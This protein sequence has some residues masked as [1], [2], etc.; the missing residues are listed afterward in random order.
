[1]N[2]R[3]PL[4]E[5]VA[6]V[7]PPHIAARSAPALIGRAARPICVGLPVYNGE[8][9]LSASL[10]DLLAQRDVD[11]E[12]VIADNCSS[13]ATEEICREAARRDGRVRYIRRERNIGVVANH[14][15][16]VHETDSELFAYGAADDEYRPNRLCRLAEALR[17]CPDAVLAFSAVLEIDAEGDAVGTWGNQCR[18]D[19]PDAAVRLYDLFALRHPFV[20]FYGLIRRAALLR[21]R[22]HPPMK[23]GDRM[24]VAELALQGTFASVPAEL[25]LRRQH[26]EKTSDLLHPRAFYPSGR[27]VTLPNIDEGRW[28]VGGIGRAPLTALAR[29]RCYAALRPWLRQNIVP[30]AKNLVRAGID[31]ANPA[32]GR[33]P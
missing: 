24:L 18:T 27:R 16:L 33:R 19:H 26:P 1:M 9:Y 23:C 17:A 25:L 28:L 12:L 8:R 5:P 11:F 10:G 14:N 32:G 3:G 4:C 6:R 2:V 22:L 31:L 13:D 20:Q 30:M 21:T 7:A 29:V 15:H